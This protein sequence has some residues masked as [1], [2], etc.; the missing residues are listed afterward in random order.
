MAN[1]LCCAEKQ[2]RKISDSQ[3][4]TTVSTLTIILVDAGS[5]QNHHY[6]TF[7]TPVAPSAYSQMDFCISHHRRVL[8]RADYADLIYV[9]GRCTT[10][11]SR[12]HDATQRCLVYECLVWM[13]GLVVVVA[14]CRL[15][16]DD[17][18]TTTIDMWPLL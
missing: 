1:C 7:K 17:A 4:T 3:Y 10:W 16:A 8:R 5:A 11:Q 13:A 15:C 18:E 9:D 6:T 12:R 2:R 14:L